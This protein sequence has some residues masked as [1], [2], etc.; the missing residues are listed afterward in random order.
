MTQYFIDEN[1][2]WQ[3][4]VLFKI[5]VVLPCLPGSHHFLQLVILI[6]QTWSLDMTPPDF[7]MW[8]SGEG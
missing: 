2:T 3:H 4:C 1:E 6:W 8:R 5:D 7:F